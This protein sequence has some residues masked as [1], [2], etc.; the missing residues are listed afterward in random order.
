M[1][2]YLDSAAQQLLQKHQLDSFDKLWNLS[3][4]AVDQP[5]TERGGYSTVS[6]LELG[7]QAFYLKR[8]R[9]HLTRSLCHPLGEP[10]FAR[11]MRNILH[12]KKLGIP[13]LEA[14]FFAQRRHN[15]EHQAI[16]LT[17][18]LDG[19]Q[20]LSY[21][22]N[23]WSELTSQQQTEII[24]ACATLAKTLHQAK[25][26]HGCFYPK[27]IFLQA[28]NQ[29]FTAKLIDLEKT[30]YLW[31]GVKDQVKDL[32][33]LFRRSSYAWGEAEMRIFLQHYLTKPY[34]L[35]Q[36]MLRLAKRRVEKDSRR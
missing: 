24:V 5:N 8:Q 6:R 18:A 1:K 17:Y 26:V 7:G 27:H 3:L 25:Q 34:N 23:Q 35:E 4:E 11:E 36:W 33:P 30:R 22:L 21:W 19:W 16:L 15:G 12:Y 29:G 9:N 28:A 20:D 32:D 14:A 10:T 2:R 13:A 31:L